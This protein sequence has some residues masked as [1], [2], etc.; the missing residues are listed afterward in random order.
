[1]TQGVI[2]RAAGMS[3]SSFTKLFRASVGMPLR[4]YVLWRRLNIAIAAIGEGSDATTA[5]HQAGFAD[6]AHFSRTMKQ[7]FGVSP[8]DGVLRIKM[9]IAA[10]LLT[11]AFHP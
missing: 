5:A 6:S 4:R 9:T 10:P 11:K 2:A 7:M 3:K 1:M 8:T